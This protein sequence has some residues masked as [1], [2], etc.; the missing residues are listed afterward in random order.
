MYTQQTQHLDSARTSM[1]ATGTT[2]T[3][4]NGRIRERVRTARTRPNKTNQDTQVAD[5]CAK[6]WHP[7][8]LVIAP[9]REVFSSR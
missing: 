8:L 7:A 3:R 2:P 4:R 1:A 5:S 6:A 9:Q